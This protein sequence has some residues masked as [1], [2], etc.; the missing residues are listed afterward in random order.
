MKVYV[1]EFIDEYERESFVDDFAYKD[2]EKALGYLTEKG[3]EYEYRYNDRYI[4][5]KIIDNNYFASVI[6]LEVLI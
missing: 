3:Y 5:T 6:E 2:F 4:F 1:I